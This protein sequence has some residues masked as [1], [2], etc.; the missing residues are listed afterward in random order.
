MND[1]NGWAGEQQTAVSHN[2]LWMVLLLG[3]LTAF[4][5]L[6]M[7]MYL[8]GLPGV[9]DDFGT[10]ASFAQLSITAA[11]IGLA[12]GQLV[13]GPMGDIKGRRRP[14]LFTLTVY[15]VASLLCVFSSN[16]WI[17]VGLRLIQ[18]ISAAA[19]IV[20]ARAASRDLYSGKELTKFIAMLALVN[21]AAPILAP[22]FGGI[23]MNFASWRFVFVILA[24]IGVVMLFAVAFTLPETLPEQNRKTGGLSETF[25]SFGILLK[26]RSFMGVALAQAFVSTSMFAYIAGSPFVLQN[27]YGITPQQFSVVFAVNGIGII[28]AAQLTG[29]LSAAINEVRMMKWGVGASFT[30]GLL[31]L[32]AVWLILPM[33]VILIA[34]FLVVSSVGV[35]NTTGFSL[36]MERHGKIA[37]SASAFLGILPFAGGGLVSP[38]VGI[39]GDQNALP[40]A[41]VIFLSSTLAFTIYHTAVKRTA[42]PLHSESTTGAVTK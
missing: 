6:S 42:R 8:P 41:I 28:I 3:S 12:I 18:G 7:D 31:L 25:Q 36:G 20:I 39:A 5:P 2:R 26:D 22:L 4:G 1:N 30:G 38:L 17:F 10:T 33:W 29:R 19:G 40:M 9:A 37:G 11:L 13:F 24:A 23:V 21:G 27:I 35:V 32:A 34:L 15:A 14:L 16:V